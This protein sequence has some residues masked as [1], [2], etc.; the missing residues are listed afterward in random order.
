[1][2]KLYLPNTCGRLLLT[3]FLINQNPCDFTK[4][5]EETQKTAM[6]NIWTFWCWWISIV[7]IVI[8]LEGNADY[9]S[10]VRQIYSWKK[11]IIYSISIL[12]YQPSEDLCCT[13]RYNHIFSWEKLESSFICSAL[14]ISPVSLHLIE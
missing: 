4:L 3:E 10:K 1:M 6:R 12:D 7:S 2:R 14:S 11:G 8:S 9:L 5:C 13:W